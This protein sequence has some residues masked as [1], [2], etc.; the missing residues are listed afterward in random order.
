MRVCV[1]V[2]VNSNVISSE[3]SF[4]DPALVG[5]SNLLLHR[6][7]ACLKPNVVACH[8]FSLV[9]VHQVSFVHRIVIPPFPSL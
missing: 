2:C 9:S 4:Q 6:A 8:R 5:P 1:C 3:L 7:Q